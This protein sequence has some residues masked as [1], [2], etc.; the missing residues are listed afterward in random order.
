MTYK[1][2][3]INRSILENFNFSNQS[4]SEYTSYD[5]KLKLKLITDT[6]FSFSYF[7]YLYKL[8]LCDHELI[9]VKFMFSQ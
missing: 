8:S 4:F 3:N 7:K 6:S 2:H 1:I 9:R 5:L